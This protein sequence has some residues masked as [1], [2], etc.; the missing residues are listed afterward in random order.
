MDAYPDVSC[1][2][3]LALYIPI[4]LSSAQKHEQSIHHL[5]H[6]HCQPA[7]TACWTNCQVAPGGSGFFG[8]QPS[9]MEN[10]SLNLGKLSQL[11]ISDCVR[12]KVES[13]VKY[14]KF[15]LVILNYFKSM[16]NRCVVSQISCGSTKLDKIKIVSELVLKPS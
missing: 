4:L 6:H 13:L 9:L 14:L 12:I 10:S 8:N 11:N 7:D 3:A 15:N 5:S 2:M 16:C 1:F